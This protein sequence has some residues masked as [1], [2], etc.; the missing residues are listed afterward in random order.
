MS[1]NKTFCSY[2]AI[3]FLSSSISSAEPKK[4]GT[5]W[6]TFLGLISITRSTP[7]VATP[8]A[9]SLIDAIVFMCLTNDRSHTT[10]IA[11]YYHLT[12]LKL[13][14]FYTKI[15]IKWKSGSKRDESLFGGG[16]GGRLRA[17]VY[18]LEENLLREL[19]F[20]YPGGKF[21]PPPLS[22]LG[23]YQAAFVKKILSKIIS[24]RCFQTVHAIAVENKSGFQ[25]T[26]LC[27]LY[28]SVLS[29]WRTLSWFMVRGVPQK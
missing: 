14:M 28:I 25:N 10:S 15:N 6:W 2:C 20:L 13:N 19:V 7:V 24:L 23:F 11:N 12:P 5:R 9:Y 26:S 16:M 4:V 27:N 8:P 29:L 3:F 1:V 17:L 22:S 18:R 21:C